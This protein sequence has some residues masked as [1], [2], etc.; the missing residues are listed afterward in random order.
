MTDL[1]PQLGLILGL[2]MI[3]GAFAGTEL[4]LVSLR[5]SQLQRLEGQSSTGA[6]LARLAREPNRFLSTIQ[7]GITVA[8]FLA[9]AAAAVTLADPLVEPLGFLG[10]LAEPAAVVLVTL[11]LAYLTLVVGEL[12]PKRVAMQRAERWG[13]FTARPLSVIATLAQPVV[14]LLSRSTNLVVRLVG[15]DPH[16]VREEVTKEELRDMVAT[17][18]GLTDEQ[19]Q[20]I[21]GGFE[22][23]ERSLLEILVPRRQVVILDAD[24]PCD[25]ALRELADA[26]HTR[27]PVAPARNLDEASAV[28]HLRA[29]LY[30]GERAVRDVATEVPVF[31]GSARVLDTLRELQTRRS[32]LALVVDEHGGVDGIVTV[33]DLVEELV[34]E[35]YDE[36]DADVAEAQRHPD[37][38]FTVAGGFPIHDLPDLG[39]EVPE[40]NYTTVAGLVLDQLGFIPRA[41]GDR[42][43]VDGWEL[44]VVA[45]F[46]RA[47]TAVH[48]RPV[49]A[50]PPVPGHRDAAGDGP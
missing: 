32:Q 20:I 28:V 30:G 43:A 38:T 12:A 8:G 14:W 22:I 9:S 35:I 3:N 13:L 33:E 29:L 18:A 17:Q 45:V 10:R 47:I 46:R 21:E 34:G 36:T 27:A 44:E 31:P 23:A 40:G 26:G 6:V 5:P 39:V 7:I 1:L 11:I 19:R 50:R 2:V 15:A 25:E 48:L 24:Q 42:I 49:A 41:A 37:G 4:A 16:L